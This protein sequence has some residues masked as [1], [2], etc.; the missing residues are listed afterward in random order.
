MKKVIF[1]FILF[2]IL[3]LNLFSQW[4][5]INNG[6]YGGAIASITFKDNK[7]F[8]A[9]KNP[10]TVYMKQDKNSDWI[11]INTG[12]E[13][14]TVISLAV[15][16]S[17][18]YA[19]TSKGGLFKSTDDG[20]SWLKVND[21]PDNLYVYC[22]S[23][24]GANIFAGTSGGIYRTTN[25][26]ASWDTVNTGLTNKTVYCIAFS[27]S[28]I[29]AGTTGY[30]TMGGGVFLSTDSG[31]NWTLVNNGLS[32]Q[33]IIKYMTV[34]GSKIFAANELDKIY[35]STDSGSNWYYAGT[36]PGYG[37]VISSLVSSGGNLYYSSMIGGI[38]ISTNNGETWA[39]TNNGLTDKSVLYLAVS[40]NDLYAGTS[41]S[42]I[43]TYS[44]TGGNWTKLNNT[45]LKESIVNAIESDNSNIYA[46][47]VDAVF[48]SADF[49]ESWKQVDNGLASR[50]ILDLIFFDNYLLA[51]TAAVS[52][53]DIYYSS[54]KGI[55]WSKANYNEQINIDC[56]ARKEGNLYAGISG[57][58]AVIKSTDMGM[59]WAAINNNSGIYNKVIYSLFFDDNDFYA[60]AAD[61]IYYSSDEG[62]S[63]AVINSGLTT[64]YQYIRLIFKYDSCIFIGG[65]YTGLYK[66]C[67]KGQSWNKFITNTRIDSVPIYSA[68]I[69]DTNIFAGTREGV[70]LSR[71][72]GI[73]WS[74]INTGLN[75]LSIN[76]LKIVP[77]FIFAGIKGE[78]VYRARLSDFGITDVANNVHFIPN[79]KIYPNPAH[80]ELFVD[81]PASIKCSYDIS[82][83]DISGRIVYKCSTE[84]VEISNSQSG[85]FGVDISGFSKGVYIIKISVGREN[86]SAIFVKE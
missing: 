19:G 2:F 26:G 12:L 81:I 32:N 62:E 16:G 15:S 30:G 24:N 66:S 76:K 74:K 42:G 84:P 39:Q 79:F 60:G 47:T 33:V 20:S 75:F 3:V 59:N 28:D 83:S 45:G 85:Q 36:I 22:I 41:G 13:D 5:E 71:D 29:F 52:G 7:I 65:N 10:G 70:L 56:F 73:S 50:Q 46:G 8:V 34:I 86:Y 77:P 67:D 61:G 44:D 63:W 57:G 64:Q 80:S 43:F 21:I 17:D 78:G 23:S 14:K 11:K 55:N 4:Q 68:A 69:I 6:L 48:S 37:S 51:G 58:K 1:S 40:G 31:D 27:G 72:G 49:G 54:D 82:I 53:G 18:I 38:L 25:N 35:Y 9:S